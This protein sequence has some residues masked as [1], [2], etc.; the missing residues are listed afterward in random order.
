MEE[1][2]HAP[3]WVTTIGTDTSTRYH[4]AQCGCEKVARVRDNFRQTVED[5]GHVVLLEDWREPSAV[6]LAVV[7]VWDPLPES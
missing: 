6:E 4:I 5:D 3:R 1:H 2:G 7:W